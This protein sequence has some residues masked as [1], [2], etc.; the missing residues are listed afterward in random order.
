M[1]A[2]LEIIALVGAALWINMQWTYFTPKPRHAWHHRAQGRGK[3]SLTPGAHRGGH[4]ALAAAG[5]ARV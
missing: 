3:W 2:K 5:R 4:G 1:I